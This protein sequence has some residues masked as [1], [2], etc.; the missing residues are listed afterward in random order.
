MN[1]RNYFLWL[2]LSG[3]FLFRLAFG[4]SLRFWSEDELQTYLIGLK[5]ALTG[6]WPYFGPDLVGSETSFKTQIPGALEGLVIGL[7]LRLCPIPESPFILLNLL[8]YGSL[9]LLAWYA[10]KRIP[11]L[12]FPLTL[13]WLSIAP[14]SLQLSTHMVNSSFVL[15]GSVLFFVG[16]LESHPV[17]RV[18]AVPEPLANAF[19]GFGLGWV[20]QFHMSWVLLPA[21]LAASLGGQAKAGKIKIPCFWVGLGFLLPASL[22][23]PSLFRYGLLQAGSGAGFASAFNENNL[24]AFF[25]ILARYLSLA[26]FEMPRFLG[27]H[28]ADRVAFL[29]GHPWILVPGLFLWG[30]GIF[31][32]LVL[33]TEW[34]RPRHPQTDWKKIKTLAALGF[35]EIYVSFWFTVKMPLSHIYYVTFPLVMIYSLYVWSLWASHPYGKRWVIAFLVIGFFFEC[36][37]R[38]ALFPGD[39]LYQNRGAVVKAMADRDYR[40]VGERRPGSLY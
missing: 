11:R 27:A 9:V 24:L 10:V 12:S 23:L 16:F 15:F 25:T 3:L 32:A 19:M 21:F 5:Y 18:G 39:S 17:F 36:G 8:S 33:L 13:V 22:L 40:E 2:L 35:L 4:L 26:S 6:L 14:W 31:Q 7:P 29:M 37:D 28:T 38:M 34:F 30:A 1:P 20:M